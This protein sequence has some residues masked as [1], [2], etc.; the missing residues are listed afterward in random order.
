MLLSRFLLKMAAM[1][2]GN[3]LNYFDSFLWT[4]AKVSAHAESVPALIINDNA[5]TTA[6]TDVIYGLNVTMA[7]RLAHNYRFYDF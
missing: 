7:I 6:A 2:L 5:F 1:T 4:G 3:K